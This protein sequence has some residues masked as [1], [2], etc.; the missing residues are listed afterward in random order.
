MY[1]V[2]FRAQ[3]KNGVIAVPLRYRGKLRENVRV[4]ILTEHQTQS[5]NLIDKLLESPLKVEDFHPLSRNEVYD[6]S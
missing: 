2:E 4:I 3:V 6:C 1:A 5:M